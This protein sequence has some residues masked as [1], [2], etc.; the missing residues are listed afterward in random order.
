[1]DPRSAKEKVL[2]NVRRALIQK[3][4]IPFDQ[5]DQNGPIFSELKDSLDV[6]FAQQFSTAGGQFIY[7]ENGE[8]L[9]EQFAELVKI[10]KWEDIHCYEDSLVDVLQASKVE[11]H[12]TRKDILKAHVGI[13]T[14][15]AL[16]ARS[17]SILVSSNTKSGRLLSIYPEVHICVAFTS[18][19]VSEIADALKVVKKRHS[20]IPS[21]LSLVTG[22][23]R[24]AD[25][26]K[27]LV[28]GAHGPKEIYT[29]L[30]DDAQ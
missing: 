12:T 2:K 16:I 28:L 20:K 6:E 17:G 1:M 4:D 21:N 29:L 30:V 22:P 10:K 19:I 26:E 14:C 15:E 5:L 8:A 18:Q 9:L 24:T 27:E 25:I 13:T 23:S 11:L 7:C 3:T